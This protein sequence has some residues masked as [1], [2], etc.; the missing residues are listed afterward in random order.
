MSVTSLKSMTQSRDVKLGHFIIEFATPGIGHILAGAGCDF[1]FFDME[2]SGFGFETVKNA[3][4]WFEA[5]GIPMLVRAPSQDYTMLARVCDVGAEGI[6]VPMVNTAAEARE[7]V[8]HIKYPPD[9]S[10]GVAMSIAHDNYYTGSLSVAERMQAANQ[11]TT[12]F[13]LVETAEGVENVEDIAAVGGI[14]CIWIGHFDLSASLGVPGE[15]EHPD[16]I[17]AVNRI[18]AAARQNN[19]SLGRLVDSTDEGISLYRQGFDFCCYAG[20]VWLLQRALSEAITTLR[21][22]CRA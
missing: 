18:A 9:G 21:E 5:A 8:A 13:C 12:L 11:R 7:I 10:R 20:D 22:G 16:Y 3:V 1:V 2:H 6:V 4:R 19:L 15:F 17:A 14:D